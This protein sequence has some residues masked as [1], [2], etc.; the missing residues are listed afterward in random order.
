MRRR[1]FLALLFLFATTAKAESPRFVQKWGANCHASFGAYQLRSVSSSG[2]PDEDDMSLSIEVGTGRAVANRLKQ[3]LFYAG[4]L[5]SNVPSQCDNVSTV[6]L[7]SGNI[8]VL[9]QR[10]D[11]P[12][13]DRVSAVLLGGK[14]GVVLDTVFDLGAQDKPAELSKRGDVIRIKLIREWRSGSPEDESVPV[15]GWLRLADTKG[16]ISYSWE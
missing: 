10:D 4:R 14:D 15:S 5:S 7:P 8:L 11:R 2:E 13:A 1:F 12:S 9:I 6:E 3:A 16:K